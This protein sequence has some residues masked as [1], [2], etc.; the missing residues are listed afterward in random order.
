MSDI[1]KLQEYI[2]HNG[3]L[4]VVAP[5]REPGCNKSSKN[6]ETAVFKSS[7]EPEKLYYDDYFFSKEENLWNSMF[8][9]YDSKE[10]SK[11]HF[12]EFFSYCGKGDKY[13]HLGI[14]NDK[15]VDLC[16]DD[17][18]PCIFEFGQRSQYLDKPEL[19]VKY[20][21]KNI[22]KKE[23]TSVYSFW[24]KLGRLQN[25]KT[26]EEIEQYLSDNPDIYKVAHHYKAEP[27]EV[28]FSVS[29]PAISRSNDNKN[30]NTFDF[31]SVELLIRAQE[32]IK[33]FVKE[34][35]IYLAEK[36]LEKIENYS[37]YQKY[38]VP[39]GFL[40]L[41]SAGTRGDSIVILN[42]QIREV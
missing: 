12:I 38:N 35:Y 24:R 29:R 5:Y 39:I 36:A 18:P 23:I 26:F 30:K 11:N 8:L 37:G 9:D 1:D 27:N 2:E 34:N 7:K 19:Y 31:V 40:T 21:P 17:L 16:L 42:F 41:Y 28:V 6:M 32:D 10:I 4:R 33:R 22:D 15:L 25:G 13:Y 14:L 20:Y 3:F